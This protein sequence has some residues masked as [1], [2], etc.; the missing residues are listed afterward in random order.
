MQSTLDPGFHAVADGNIATVVT[1]L[2]M[3]TAPPPCPEHSAPE[4]RLELWQ[5][6]DPDA[7]RILFRQVGEDWLWC[8]R[9]LM[10][11]DKL[12]GIIHDPRVEIRRLNAPNG[13]GLL[14]LDFRTEGECELAFFGLSAGLIGGGAG[15]WM[16]NRALEIA[17][18]RPLTRLWVHTCTMDHPRAVG[19][20]RRSGFVPLGR[21]VEIMPD[22][23]IIGLLPETAAPH[24]PCLRE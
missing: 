12:T 17:W 19:F 20:Y 14:E 16:M 21:Q 3:R 15:R 4:L 9:L 2:E 18:S 7:Y 1:S 22:P 23:R 10:A 8:S 11:D 13:V 5:A 6:P 24:I